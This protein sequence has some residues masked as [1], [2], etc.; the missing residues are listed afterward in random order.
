MSVN[1]PPRSRKAGTPRF[2]APQP[3]LTL[4]RAETMRPQPEEDA[5]LKALLADDRQR[6]YR[7]QREQQILNDDEP[8]AA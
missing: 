8:E 4:L 7:V 3:K 1:K 2:P 5:E 6:R